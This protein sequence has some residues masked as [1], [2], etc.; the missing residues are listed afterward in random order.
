MYKK[1]SEARAK[2]QH[3][4]FTVNETANWTFISDKLEQK[5]NRIVEESNRWSSGPAGFLDSEYP[6]PMRSTTTVSTSQGRA[7]TTTI[8][9]P[10]QG[11]ATPVRRQ[12]QPEVSDVTPYPSSGDTLNYA[13]V[14]LVTPWPTPGQ[15]APGQFQCPPV[16][17]PQMEAPIRH[18]HPILPGQP[19]PP[20]PYQQQVHS[21]PL[22][23]LQAAGVGR[24][25]PQQATPAQVL[26][27]G[28]SQPHRSSVIG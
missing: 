11:V 6:P 5:G 25:V 16:D 19:C 26:T 2:D 17:P 15:H 27:P 8:G 3:Y 24:G 1:T 12:P 18:T 13:A 22:Q 20:T 7:P 23:Y 4:Q 9:A 14:T 21:H 10:L 28:I